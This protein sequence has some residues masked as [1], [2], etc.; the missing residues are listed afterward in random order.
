MKIFKSKVQ[1]SKA[2]VS[3]LLVIRGISSWTLELISVKVN[4]AV[5][6]Y[7]LCNVRQFLT[8]VCYRKISEM[9]FGPYSCEIMFWN[10]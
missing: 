7:I 10:L 2:I 9:Q 3:E 8:L 5:I 4:F 6:I 1:F